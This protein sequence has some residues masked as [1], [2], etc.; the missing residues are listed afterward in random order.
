MHPSSWLCIPQFDAAY[1]ILLPCIA[2]PPLFLVFLRNSSEIAV[3]G[4]T[5]TTKEGSSMRIEIM[6]AEDKDDVVSEQAR[7]S[8]FSIISKG[9]I[10]Y[11]RQMLMHTRRNCVPSKEGRYA[12][13]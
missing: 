11:E 2:G 10:E 9:L 4:K 7:D 13:V 6:L 3:N 12:R 5:V 1:H 8:T